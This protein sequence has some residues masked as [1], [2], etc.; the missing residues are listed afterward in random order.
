MTQ[1]LNLLKSRKVFDEYFYDG[2]YEPLGRRD[3][4]S[5]IIELLKG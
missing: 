1:I 5:Q 2:M 4:L 3:A